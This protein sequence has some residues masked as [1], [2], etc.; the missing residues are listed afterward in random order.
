MKEFLI[1]VLTFFAPHVEMKKPIAQQI[2]AIEFCK[3]EAEIGGE[4]RS[5]LKRELSRSTDGNIARNSR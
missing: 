4:F 3:L 5:C 1:Y 2:E